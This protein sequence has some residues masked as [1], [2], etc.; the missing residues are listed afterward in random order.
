MDAANGDGSKCVTLPGI[1]DHG[2]NEKKNLK[3]VQQMR[4]SGKKFFAPEGWTNGY[5]VHIHEGTYYLNFISDRGGVMSNDAFQHKFNDILEQLDSTQKEQILFYLEDFRTKCKSD[6]TFP[7]NEHG[8]K[9]TCEE[10]YEKI[11]GLSDDVK[12]K[13]WAEKKRCADAC[14]KRIKHFKKAEDRRKTERLEKEKRKKAEEERRLQL[15]K[16]RNND[17]LLAALNGL[18]KGLVHSESH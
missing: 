11:S 6:P 3:K 8:Q 5:N 14:I 17:A 4:E 2:F 7:Y 15:I 18:L 16:E 10:F 9:L 13:A 1:N 12:M